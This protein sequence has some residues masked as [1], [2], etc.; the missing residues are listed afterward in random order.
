MEA[1]PAAAALVLDRSGEKRSLEG[2]GIFPRPLTEG[3][4]TDFFGEL[5]M[6]WRAKEL[7]LL[8][9]TADAVR[10][11]WADVEMDGPGIPLGLS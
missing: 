7:Q 5:V 9:V 10:V 6:V 1:A 2:A 8:A 4:T 11:G 3:G